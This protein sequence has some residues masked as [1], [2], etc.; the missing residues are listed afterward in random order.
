MGPT[1][2]KPTNKN[3]KDNTP[4]ADEAE[5]PAVAAE[6]AAETD[7]PTETDDSPEKWKREAEEA[8]DKYLRLAAELEN[9][10]RRSE[11]LL[12][13]T[14]KFV[15]T[16]FAG[17]IC[18][19]RDCLEIALES[20]DNEKKDERRRLP[21]PAQTGDDNGR[22]THPAPAPR[23]RRP[24]RP[25]FTPSHRRRP[26]ADDTPPDTVATLV[27]CGYMLNG[28]VIPR[29]QSHRHKSWRTGIGKENLTDTRLLSHSQEISNG[30]N[31][32]H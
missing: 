25:E 17:A 11:K 7:T 15:L 26:V 5:T 1:T 22:T 13:E 12:S 10:A 9:V 29:R 6:E 32:W 8:R 28:R 4:E 23:H 18:E 19:V 30:K 14:R 31:H 2:D 24:L 3:G 20:G 21:H 16:D 27:Q